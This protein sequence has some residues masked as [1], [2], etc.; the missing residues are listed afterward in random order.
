MHERIPNIRHL[1]AFSAIAAHGSVTR[2]ARAIH[3]TQP[4]LTQAVSKLEASIGCQLFDREP[5]GMRPTHAANLLIPGVQSALKRIG[6]HRVTATQIRA[7]LA[8]SHA[9]GYAAAAQQTGLSAAALHRAIADLSL[10]LGVAL[11]ERRGR[12]IGFT[13]AGRSRARSFGL[14]LADLRNGFE[15]VAD[16]LGKTSTRMVIGAMPLSRAR[17][18]PEALLAF[19]RDHPKVDVSIVEGSYSDLEGPL[20]TGEIDFLLGA[21]RDPTALGD[22]VQEHVFDD[23]PVIVMRRGHPLASQTQLRRRSLSHYDWV[24]PGP[25]TPLYRYWKG[26]FDDT[27]LTPSQRLVC[28]SV[29]TIREL[30]LNSDMLTLLSPDQFLIESRAGLLAARRPP[31]P[32]SRSIGITMRRDWRPTRTQSAMLDILRT[33]SSHTS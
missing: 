17:W 12:H 28:G 14:A 30:L 13:Q 21:L 10:A 25:N 3:L 20:R 1:A 27:N 19:H 23:E 6:S 7:F 24:L 33:V 16:W 22:L 15:D 18:L 29:L 2:A 4:A 8:L 26:L 32:I 11:V 31:A 9:G 5:S